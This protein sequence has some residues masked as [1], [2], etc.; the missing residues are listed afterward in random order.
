MN[1]KR[2]VTVALLLF[3]AA[4]AVAL[5]I[6]EWNKPHTAGPTDVP[7]TDKVIA[8]YFHR[9]ERCATCNKMEAHSRE[10][11]ESAFLEELKSGRLQWRVVNYQQ[12]QNEHFRGE[13]GLVAPSLVLVA[14]R[15]GQQTEFKDLADIWILVDDK[16][17]FMDYVE[18]ELRAFLEEH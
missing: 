11:I 17:A 8:Y 10:A 1:A 12:P 2:I 4:S 3:V 16:N 15:E 9:T 18:R 14:L 7:Q 13:F 6:R 5:G